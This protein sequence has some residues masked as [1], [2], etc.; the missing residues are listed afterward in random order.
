MTRLCFRIILIPA[1]DF[2]RTLRSADGEGVDVAVLR[3]GF[4]LASGDPAPQSPPPTLGANTETLL[5][6]L[7]YTQNDIATLRQEDAI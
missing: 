3:T 1:R 4:R 5:R 7:G 6:D 2:V